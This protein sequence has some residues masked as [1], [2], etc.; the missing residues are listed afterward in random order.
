MTLPNQTHHSNQT[1]HQTQ[2]A[3]R[4]IGD[5]VQ[6]QHRVRRLR[7]VINNRRNHLQRLLHQ[8]IDPIRQPLHSITSQAVSCVNCVRT[9][10]FGIRIFD[11]V[12]AQANSHGWMSRERDVKGLSILSY[13]LVGLSR[14]IS[15]IFALLLLLPEC[16]DFD[17]MATWRLFQHEHPTV[18][19]SLTEVW[20]N[21]YNFGRVRFAWHSNWIKF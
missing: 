20:T 12:F 4:S 17:P 11:L 1:P 2:P 13:L 10:V 15:K 7:F 9:R 21:W 5:V 16:F 14:K 18:S 19:E 8:L 3:F 6:K